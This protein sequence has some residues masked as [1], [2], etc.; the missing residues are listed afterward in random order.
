VRASEARLRAFT[1]LIRVYEGARRA[2]G[3][4][5]AP[6]GD[7]DTIAPSLYAGRPRRRPKDASTS[8]PAEPQAPAAGASDTSTV[9]AVGHATSTTTLA[10]PPAAVLPP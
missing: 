4:L 10:L 5:R 6:E 2:V 8:T 7:A 3:Y 1:R 9:P